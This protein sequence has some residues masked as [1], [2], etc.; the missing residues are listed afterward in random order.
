MPPPPARLITRIAAGTA[1][2]QG[3]IEAPEVVVADAGGDFQAV[4]GLPVEHQIGAPFAPLA[5]PGPG[6]LGQAGDHAG[7]VEQV[8]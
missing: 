1:F 6:Q 3:G 5:A 8:L 4:G 2:G 7:Q